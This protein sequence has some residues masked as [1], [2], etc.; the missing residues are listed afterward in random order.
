[1]IMDAKEVMPYLKENDLDCCPECGNRNGNKINLEQEDE[2]LIA[3][4]A[5][6]E[7]QLCWGEPKPEE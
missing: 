2:E 3:I 5:C 4:L 6:A 1:M 7:C